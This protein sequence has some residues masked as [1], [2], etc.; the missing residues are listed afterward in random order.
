MALVVDVNGSIPGVGSASVEGALQIS[1]AGEV[2]LLAIS[3]NNGGSTNYGSGVSLQLSAELA[4]NTTSSPVSSIGGVPLTSPSGSHVTIAANT[5][6]I[7]AS[8]T[9]TL[10]IGGNTGFVISGVF[11][12]TVSVLRISRPRRSL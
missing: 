3:G 10:N 11:S 1:S 9:L 6:A 4:I 2:A 5:Y 8:G 7:I 12:T